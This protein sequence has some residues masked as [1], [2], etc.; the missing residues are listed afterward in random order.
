MQSA[1]IKNC[2]CGNSSTGVT[3]HGG[4]AKKKITKK[5]SK[6]KYGKL[7][8]YRKEFLKRRCGVNEY[9]VNFVPNIDK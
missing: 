7:I 8:S 2:A 3:N 4:Q 9:W 1:T 5:D 6:H